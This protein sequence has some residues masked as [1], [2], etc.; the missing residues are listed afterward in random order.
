MTSPTAAP[1]RAVFRALIGGYEQLREEDVARDSDLPFICF[2][3]DPT[4]TST[5]WQVELVEA[6]F[7]RDATRSARAL[8]ILGHPLLDDYDETLWV[9]NT[10]ALLEPPDGL[11]DEWLAEGD[12]AAPL[13]SHRSSVLAEAEAV[14]DAGLDD[15]S[16]VYEQLTHYLTADAE[17]LDENPHWTG[18]LARRRTP[19]SLAAMTGWWE[20]VLRYSRRDQVSF[21]PAMRRHGVRLSSVPIEAHGSRWHEWPCAE[22]R[23]RSRSGSGLREVLRPPAARIGVLEQALDEATRTL[24]VSVTHREEII[25]QHDVTITSLHESLAEANQRAHDTQVELDTVRHQRNLTAREL[26]EARRR[27]RRLKQQAKGRPS[28][29]ERVWRRLRRRVRRRG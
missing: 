4:L 14:L 5:T 28:R 23:D 22:G 24:A 2:T 3:D 19:A 10:V 6:R 11:F 20:D 13:H 27:I 12:V 18:M 25:A 17:V 29:S 7:P 15:Y 21:L 16:R 8:K 1:R 26:N 9:D